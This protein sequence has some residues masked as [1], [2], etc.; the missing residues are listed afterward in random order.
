MKHALSVCITAVFFIVNLDAEI[1]HVPGEY[2]TIQEAIDAS[3]KGDTVLLQP[4]IYYENVDFNGKC[5]TLASLY[6]TTM[7]TS[8]IRQTI[9]DGSGTGRVITINSDEDAGTWLAGL[10]IRNGYADYGGGILI[11]RADPRVSNCII[12][13]NIAEC[14]NGLGG[15]MRL[16][17]TYSIVQDCIIRFNSALGQD[18]NNGG[19]GGIS[20]HNSHASIFTCSITDND[21]TGYYGGIGISGGAPLVAGCL[22]ARNRC[23]NT[24]GAGFQDAE[25][26]FANNTVVCNTASPGL[27]GG[28]YFIRSTPTLT[29]CII[30]YNSDSAGTA[31]NFNGWGGTPNITN[32]N[33]QGGYAS[34]PVMDSD[35]LFQDM[36]GGNYRLAA[37]SPCIDAGAPAPV[38][39]VT[40][41]DGRYRV[42]DGD[43]N[44]SVLIDMGAYEYGSMFVDVRDG[45]V[46]GTPETC[47]L[48]QNF[49]NP[50]NGETVITFSLPRDG[51]AVLTVFDTRGRKIAVIEDGLFTAGTH[52]S[53]W[54]AAGFASGVYICRLS[55]ETHTQSIKL[56]LQR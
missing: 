23:H 45:E 36:A 54:N 47:T 42:H 3:V 22:I 14:S 49:P 8:Y 41:L 38:P 11:Y 28:I 43:G 13:H 52:R 4:D 32:C 25:P 31:Y 34:T 33:I 56:L 50:F 55:T 10:T 21:A 1:R 53:T 9:I 40:D 37:G 51:G 7:D 29:N 18:I 19:C 26:L 17:Q 24:A 44:G 5:V 46:S 16:E 27:M 39:L 30:W 48:A 6:I 15:G 35:P 12:E 2:A 20:A